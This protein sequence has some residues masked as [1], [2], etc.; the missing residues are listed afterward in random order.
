MATIFTRIINREVPAHIVAEDENHI[1]FLDINPLATG[2]TLV[3]AK[4]EVDDLFALES[5]ALQALMA[6]TQKV[7][8]TLKQ[9]ISCRRVIMHV[10]GFEVPHAHI[11]LIPVHTAPKLQLTEVPPSAAEVLSL[12]QIGEKLRSA[13][14]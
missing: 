5:D 14:P 12:E 10:A 1:A 8:A 2:H 7:A 11:H 6:F 3:A 13:M 9:E 4:Q